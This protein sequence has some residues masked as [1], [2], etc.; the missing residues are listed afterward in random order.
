MPYTEA[1]IA[2]STRMSAIVPTGVLHKAMEDVKFHGYDIPKGT[3][4]MP[5]VHCIHYDPRY[6]DEPEEFR[7][8]RFLSAD[9]KTLKK[10]DA[11]MPF[12]VGKRQCLGETLARDTIFLYFTNIF[13]RFSIR[14]AEE[15]KDATLEPA[16]GFLLA[17]QDYI[18]ILRERI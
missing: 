10:H 4:I 9:G 11:F 14:L 3:M 2:E 16:V 12:S 18:V 5:N 1:I 8:E 13:H 6:W 15:S 7:P 17:P